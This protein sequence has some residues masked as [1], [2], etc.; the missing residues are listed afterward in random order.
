[1]RL[2][3]AAANNVSCARR[4]THSGK[5]DWNATATGIA[6]SDT[7]TARASTVDLENN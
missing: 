2:G 3:I 6:G 1:M 4:F 5:V 7:G